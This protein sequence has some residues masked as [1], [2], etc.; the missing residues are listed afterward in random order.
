MTSS[1][2]YFLL[3]CIKRSTSGFNTVLSLVTKI[4]K[5]SS[6]IFS[7]WEKYILCSQCVLLSCTWR[8]FLNWFLTV[9]S[10]HITVLPPSGQLPRS[11]YNTT[12]ETCYYAM[13]LKK[14]KYERIYSVSLGKKT[15]N[16]IYKT[17]HN[18]WNVQTFNV[19]LSWLKWIA[20]DM[21]I[22]IPT[23]FEYVAPTSLVHAVSLHIKLKHC[24][25]SLRVLDLSHSSK[26]LPSYRTLWNRKIHFSCSRK[27]LSY[28]T[29]VDPLLGTK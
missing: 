9:A 2:Y 28:W 17:F 14:Q 18:D 26:V 7:T 19:S 24:C 4:M 27:K 6:W 23:C 22:V 15:L 5:Y 1:G 8:N 16:H 11:N 12:D 21:T 25:F 3:Q 10:I 13:F 20:I 29:K